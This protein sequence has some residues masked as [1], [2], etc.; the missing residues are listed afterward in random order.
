M[1]TI[2]SSNIASRPTLTGVAL[3]G[4]PETMLW[5]LHNRANE[6]KRNDAIIDDPLAIRIYESIDYDYRLHFGAPDDSHSMRS[7]LFDDAIKP[8]LASHPGGIVV[9]LGCGLETQFQRCDDGKV[10]WFCVDMPVAIN[11]RERFIPANERCQ[12]IRR[13]ALDYLWMDRIDSSKSIF[14]TAQGLF[15]Y[16]DELRVRELIVEIFDQFDDVQLMFD[17]IPQW[18]SKKTTSRQGFHRTRHY[19]APPMPWG[20]NRG[21]IEP[22]LRSWSN[23]MGSVEIVPYGFFRGIKGSLLKHVFAKTPGLREIP[24]YIVRIHSQCGA[25]T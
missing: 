13:S 15:M 4:V 25:P 2:M 9:E 10:E 22:T 23:K 12:Y 17:V 5:T 6:A 21:K 19:R 24:P 14:I 18:F 16:F 20:I 7:R 8:W 11:V 1:E 3:D